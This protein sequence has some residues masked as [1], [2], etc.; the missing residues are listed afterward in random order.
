MACANTVW[1]RL[2]T[3][4]SIADFIIWFKDHLE[5]IPAQQ[6][7]DV[8][9]RAEAYAQREQAK[10]PTEEEISRAQVLLSALKYASAIAPW[11]QRT[12]GACNFK[13]KLLTR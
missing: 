4:I 6:L 1:F 11:L 5:L 2:K 3:A 13:D 12:V 8:A 7:A 9:A 10:E